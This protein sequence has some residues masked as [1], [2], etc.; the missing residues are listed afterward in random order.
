MNRKQRCLLPA[1]ACIVLL[2]LQAVAINARAQAPKT[3]PK[4]QQKIEKKPEPVLGQ[5]APG[6]GRA[7][8]ASIPPA[9]DTTH[10]LTKD[11]VVNSKGIKTPDAN[12]FI[13]RWL[14]MEPLKDTRSNSAMTESYLRTTL[15]A[16]NFSQ[17]YN[18]IPQHSQA[19]TV[20]G[21]ELKW[22]ALDSKQFDFNL[23]HFS[24][25]T[26]TR[27]NGVLFWLVTVINC[28]EDIKNVKLS[29]GVNSAGMFWINGKEVLLV[30][31]DENVIADLVTSRSLTLK[32]GKNIV[33]AAVMNGQGMCTFCVRFLDENGSPVKNYTISY[34]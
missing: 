24:Y 17:D 5:I 13:Q 12:G 6:Q 4:T 21:Q 29:A 22:Y 3:T 7:F 1:M 20:S 32:K 28:N 15:G 31:G 10:T 26:N 2:G 25:A 23:Y 14:V 18:A 34:Q 16:E 27:R 11:F 9:G 33:R 30:P 19:N 8:L